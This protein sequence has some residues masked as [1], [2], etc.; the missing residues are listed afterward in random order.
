MERGNSAFSDA[1]KQLPIDTVGGWVWIYNTAA[2]IR[3]GT[4]FGT[5]A[6]VLK[7]KLSLDWTGPFKVLAVGPS[8][9]D[10]TPD[11]CPLAGK[12]F[13][14]GLLNDMPGH[15]AHCRISVA[16]CKPCTNAHDTTDL[17]PY[18]PAGFTQDVLNNYSTKFPAVSTS[19]QTTSPCPSSTWRPTRLPATGPHE[20][21]AESS[22]FSTK[23]TGKG[24]LRPSWERESDFLHS[25]QH[26]EYWAGTPLQLRQ[27]NRV[28]SCVRGCHSTR[29]RPRQGR[30]FSASRIQLSQSPNVDSPS[31]APSCLSAST[32]GT[33]VKIIFGGSENFPRTLQLLDN[34][35]M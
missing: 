21:G 11:G 6:K 1:L 10:F 14:L 2:T 22:L 26:T 12:L 34:T 23:H 24:L 29:A 9:S 25:R 19:Q 32:S 15:G 28:P 30:P 20:A 13:Y 27:A 17:P 5:G 33:R 7:A 18:L 8:P 31:V 3:H 35:N 16:R 4:K